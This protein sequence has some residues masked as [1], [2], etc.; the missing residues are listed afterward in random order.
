ML[1][2]NP[3]RKVL[4]LVEVD[5]HF[6]LDLLKPAQFLV[7]QLSL[8]LAVKR[9]FSTPNS[10]RNLSIILLEIVH[11]HCKYALNMVSMPTITKIMLAILIGTC[12]MVS[13]WE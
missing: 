11:S 3:W 2:A 9:V 12:C 5:L 1:N 10:W 4:L 6:F 8:A 7:C 13:H